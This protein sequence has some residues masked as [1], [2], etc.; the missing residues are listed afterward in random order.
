M[1]IGILTFH[2]AHN[3][4]AVLQAYGLQE[5]LKT[6]GHEVEIIDYRPKYLTQPYRAFPTPKLEGASVPRKVWRIYRWLKNLPRNLI[7]YPAQKKR[8]RGFEKFISKK[9]NLSAEPFSQGRH[10]PVENYDAIIFGSDQIW[11]PGITSNDTVF[12]GDFPTP[13]GTLKIAYA[14][15]A[16]GFAETLGDNPLYA[17]SLKNFDAISVRESNLGKSLQ[18]HTNLKIET[19][20]DPTLLAPREVWEKLAKTPQAMPKKY[21]LVYQVSYKPEADKL[22]AEIAEKMGAEVVSIFAGYVL[23]SGMRKTETPEEFVG[24]FKNAA[25]VVTTSFHGT[26]FSLIFKKSFYFVGDGDAGENRPRQILSAL[27]LLDRY[28]PVSEKPEFSEVNYDEIENEM[29][30]GY[31]NFTGTFFRVSGAS[32]GNAENAVEAARER[33]SAFLARVLTP[34]KIS[35]GGRRKMKIGILTQPLHT[36]YGGLLQAFAMQKILR[37]RGHDALTIDYRGKIS[38]RRRAYNFA[39]RFAKFLLRKDVLLFPKIAKEERTV[40]NTTRFVDENI[41]T[42]KR[43]F[44]PAKA[45]NFARYGFDAFVV[46]SDQVWR[47]EYSPHMPTFFLDFLDGNDSRTRRIAYAASFGKD[48]WEFSPAETQIFSALAKKFHAISVR[49]DSG[50]AL[51]EKFLGVHAEH[52]LDPTLLLDIADYTEI[53]AHDE[54]RGFLKKRVP[55]RRLFAYVLDSTLEKDALVAETAKTL[56][57]ETDTI[58]TP[59]PEEFRAGTAVFPP[60]SAWLR[61]FRDSEFVVTDSFHG[62][63]F[64]IL[65]NRPFIAIGNDGRGM[66]RFISLLK[67][68]G[69]EERLVNLG[70]DGSVSAFDGNALALRKI[71]WAHVG[72]ILAEERSRAHDFLDRAFPRDSVS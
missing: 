57:L 18:A 30:G 27:G 19:V 50:V 72:E 64:S 16:G 15:S 62:C 39:R 43:I 53:V 25:A 21:V 5:F 6:L 65:F 48:E 7:N 20:L 8:C 44:A 70:N 58:A 54:A 13:A 12:L 38:R 34:R 35:N 46:G 71:D 55:A 1:K 33:A 51:C 69:L 42:T 9:L 10:V 3:Y 52:L 26:A 23:K 36:N 45:Q 47:P 63:V 67:K 14:A 66:S 4:G 41:R 24:W 22:A 68:F 2:C 32:L 40:A 59:T 37:K 61:G 31:A 60:V 11:S 49:E 17:N 28:V 29:G 56:A